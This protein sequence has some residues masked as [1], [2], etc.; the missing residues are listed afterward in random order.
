MS[1]ARLLGRRSTTIEAPPVPLTVGEALDLHGLNRQLA[2]DERGPVQ[3][4]DRLLALD[5]ARLVTC[6]PV[7]A[8][9]SPYLTG[10]VLVFPDEIVMGW[11][12][13][14]DFKPAEI[15]T[16]RWAW[17]DLGAL[18]IGPG[19]GRV[20][21]G[22]AT[23]PRVSFSTERRFR[24]Q[25]ESAITAGLAS[26]RPPVTFEVTLPAAVADLVHARATEACRNAAAELAA[27]VE[28]AVVER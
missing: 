24:R 15:E 22:F 18:S 28:R 9:A 8:W 7:T 16:A 1:G 21:F 26:L 4:L 11:R 12:K 2:P 13:L 27:I 23:R 10:V 25:L 3:A 5:L 17:A 6:A 19:E 20:T 14:V